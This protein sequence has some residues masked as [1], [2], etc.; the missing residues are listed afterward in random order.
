[1]LSLWSREYHGQVCY[2]ILWPIQ[3]SHLTFSVW[4]SFHILIRSDWR[5]SIFIE[6]LTGS[7]WIELWLFRYNPFILPVNNSNMLSMILLFSLNLKPSIKSFDLPCFL[8]QTQDVSNVIVWEVWDE[9]WRY[10]QTFD[11]FFLIKI[12]QL[13]YDPHPNLT[14]WL[15]KTIWEGN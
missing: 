1:M 5:Q 8:D 13:L 12:K 15:S 4:L 6:I 2:K 9:L 10:N 11:P 14:S 7:R 3:H